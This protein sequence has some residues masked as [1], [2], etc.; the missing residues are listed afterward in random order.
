MKV[1]RV[2][3]YLVTLGRVRPFKVDKSARGA[4]E[5]SR[6]G[7]RNGGQKSRQCVRVVRVALSWWD[8]AAGC[9]LNPFFTITTCSPVT[10]SE[11]LPQEQV[12][13]IKPGLLV[14]ST[15]GL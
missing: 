5:W 15:S 10:L 14:D 6:W 13:L 12:Q 1:L 8:L 2:V 4:C 7:A 9:V 11:K 3:M